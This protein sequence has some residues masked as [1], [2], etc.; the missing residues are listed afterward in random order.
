MVKLFLKRFICI[1]VFEYIPRK[2]GQTGFMYHQRNA[3]LLDALF[4]ENVLA[5]ALLRS[6]SVCVTESD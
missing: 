5:G 4:Q 6:L 1:I 2:K 3:L